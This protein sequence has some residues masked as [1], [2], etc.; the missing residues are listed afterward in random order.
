[1]KRFVIVIALIA[2]SVATAWDTVLWDS[3]SNIRPDVSKE[4]GLYVVDVSVTNRTK[5]GNP[6]FR[7]NMG[8]VPTPALYDRASGAYVPWLGSIAA[9]ESDATNRYTML[10][11]IGQRELVT[12]GAAY[13]L[14]AK[15]VRRNPLLV[16]EAALEHGRTNA[17]IAGTRPLVRA[18]GALRLLESKESGD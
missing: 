17:T 11:R 3:S 13:G 2:A 6:E 1:M 16:V 9:S 14:A 12:M 7:A 5:I 18:L 8:S 4:V 15:R 10:Q